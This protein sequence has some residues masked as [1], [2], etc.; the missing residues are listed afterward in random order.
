LPKSFIFYAF[1][2]LGLGGALQ[3]KGESYLAGDDFIQSGLDESLGGLVIYYIS[4][5]WIFVGFIYATITINREGVL[6]NVFYLTASIVNIFYIVPTIFFRYAI[7]LKFFFVFLLITEFY[8]YKKIK[9][10]YLFLLIFCMILGTQIIV[11]RNNIS[12][13]FLNSNSLLMVIILG[14]GTMGPNDFLE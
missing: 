9:V 14:N 2:N 10:A 12:K 8:K 6:R 13:S 5:L 7:I 4:L 3:S 1:E 11:A